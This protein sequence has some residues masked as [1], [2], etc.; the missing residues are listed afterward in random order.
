VRGSCGVGRGRSPCGSVVPVSVNP[1]FAEPSPPGPWVSGERCLGC[2][3][4]Y[5]DFRGPLDFAAAADVLRQAAKTAGDDGGGYR[6]RGPVLWVMRVFKLDAWFL[7]HMECGRDG[8]VDEA[9]RARDGRGR[10]LF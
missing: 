2:G 9:G 1:L 3:E 6:S 4:D 5:G 10:V 8:Y 7:Q